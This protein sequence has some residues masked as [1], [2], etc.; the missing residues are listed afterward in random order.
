MMN[1]SLYDRHYLFFLVLL[2]LAA[3]SP[4][5]P[6]FEPQADETAGRGD[7]G[8]M[9]PAPT[10]II[11]DELPGRLL[12]VQ[13]GTIWIWQGQKARPLLG[14]GTATQPVWSPDG[15]LIAYIERGFSYSDMMLADAGGAHLTQL[16]FNGSE[17]PPG[18]H[19]RIFESMWTFY[20]AWSPD[21]EWIVAAAQYAPPSGSPA[22]EY[23]MSLYRLP[24]RGGPREQLYSDDGAHSGRAVFAPG[25]ATLTYTRAATDA[26][27][28]LQLYSF[29]LNRTESR[30]YPGAPPT[31]YDPAYSA[32]G[33][34]LVFAAQDENG[35]D[36]WVLPAAASGSNQ[37]P[38][39]LT[40]LGTARAPVFAPDG[41]M[42]AFLAIP[43]G[44]SGFELW[45]AE[46]ERD[47]NG[48]LRL[49]EPR[50]LT[51]GMRLDADGGL[52]WVE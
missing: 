11:G 18:S 35:T 27:G 3:C 17:Q 38:Q 29:D 45:V 1:R 16:T 6:A 25:G 39:R 22:R 32:D 13:N 33:Q 8:G 43:P 44:Q 5:P 37:A 50:Q 4:A 49:A 30:P 15:Q 42:L 31:S 24:A 9:A 19:A 2:V 20:P 10:S 23:N 47:A 52:S 41:S 12:F 14:N 21:G 28:A 34:W 26:E 36:I 7:G 40:R 51:E 46:L 48:L